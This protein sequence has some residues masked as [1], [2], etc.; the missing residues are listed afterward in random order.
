L[1]KIFQSAITWMMNQTSSISRMV[2]IVSDNYNI[3]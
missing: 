3:M 1:V 2:V